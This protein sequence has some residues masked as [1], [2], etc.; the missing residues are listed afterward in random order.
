MKQGAIASDR[1]PKEL[2]LVR[3]AL[4]GTPVVFLAYELALSL[5]HDSS[6]TDA[7]PGSVANTIP[8]VLFGLIVYQII[9]KRLVGRSTRIQVVG[10]AFLCAAYSLLSY[11]LLIV[12]L[13]AVNGF[14]VI[15]FQV[16]PFPIRA[17][18]W[19]LLQNATTYGIIAVLAYR[20]TANP[21][22]TLV[23]ANEDGQARP[24]RSRY[25]IRSGDE[26][27]PID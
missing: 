12:L 26:I 23:L 9:R 17:S 16:E 3:L 25:F 24:G 1:V 20:G 5:G 2:S 19:Q 4:V 27:Q 6:L 7:L 22:V 18:V 11:W 14:S 10:H 15:Q 21:E 13:G 8:A